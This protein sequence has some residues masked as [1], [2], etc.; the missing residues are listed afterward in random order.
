MN[1]RIKK[2]CLTLLSSLPIFTV[3]TLCSC[4]SHNQEFSNIFYGDKTPEINKKNKKEAMLIASKHFQEQWSVADYGSTITENDF[5]SKIKPKKITCYEYYW[6]IIYYFAS[7]CN[8]K[9]VYQIVDWNSNKSEELT[10]KF[11]IVLKYPDGN[12]TLLAKDSKQFEYGFDDNGIITITFDN[13]D[14]YTIPS[15]IG[16]YI[17]V[18]K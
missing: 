16:S 9:N 1:I 4:S 15:Y 12:H 14:M 8:N 10:I 6:N 7:I 5:N 17:K 18:I 2:N 11:D 13:N 3:L